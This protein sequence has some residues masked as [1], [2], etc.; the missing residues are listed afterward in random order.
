MFLMLTADRVLVYRL[1][2]GLKSRYFSGEKEEVFAK[3]KFRRKLTPD[4]PWSQRLCF[5]Y[6]LFMWK[7]AT[8]SADRSAEP[9][10]KKKPLVEIVE[11]LSFMLTQHLT[12][13]KDVIF[14]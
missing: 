12:A 6:Y 4:V 13:A 8:R 1:D 11:N 7:F 2:R 14:F 3:A 10:R 9:E 5:S